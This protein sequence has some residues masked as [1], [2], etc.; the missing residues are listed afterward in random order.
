MLIWMGLEDEGSVGRG[1]CDQTYYMRKC[2]QLKTN[3]K[4]L[5]V[6]SDSLTRTK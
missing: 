4:N 3:D 2:F 6:V 5:K 1:N